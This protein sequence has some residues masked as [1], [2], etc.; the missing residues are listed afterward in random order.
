MGDQAIDTFRSCIPLFHALGDP[1]R[2]DI[3]LLL[4]E[5]ER[6]TVNEIA[7]QSRL[8]RPAISHHLKIL[9]DQGLV[10]TEQ[11][12]TKRFYS[13]TLE[14][15]VSMLKKLISLVEETCM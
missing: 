13:L 9:K 5:T 7:D 10:V 12:G 2:Q 8:S 11:Q 1:A 3:I 15:S 4:A 14:D 6:L